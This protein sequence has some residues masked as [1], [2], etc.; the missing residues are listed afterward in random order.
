[1][2]NPI[3]QHPP[4]DSF[5]ALNHI[6]V[7]QMPSNDLQLLYGNNT[8]E[9][10]SIMS[11]SQKQDPHGFFKVS[12]IPYYAFNNNLVLHF[13]FNQMLDFDCH[14]YRGYR[15]LFGY[16]G[17][18][19]TLLVDEKTIVLT[20]IKNNFYSRSNVMSFKYIHFIFLK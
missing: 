13:D 14:S 5:I 4:P 17:S 9:K 10:P 2:F 6:K 3:T 16:F 20:S 15:R 1:M 8:P 7:R 12:Q 19:D 18:Q 11:I